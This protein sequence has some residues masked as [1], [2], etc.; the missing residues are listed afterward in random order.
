MDFFNSPAVL[1]IPLITLVTK[2]KE[3]GLYIYLCTT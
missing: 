2:T 1:S 3:L